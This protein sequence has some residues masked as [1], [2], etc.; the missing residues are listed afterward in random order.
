MRPRGPFFCLRGFFYN[1]WQK[2]FSDLRPEKKCFLLRRLKTGLACLSGSSD[3]A[4]TDPAELREK[5]QSFFVFKF[6]MDFSIF[7]IFPLCE[8]EFCIF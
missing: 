1:N 6:D 7:K 5:K 4:L 3:G 2:R 8:I